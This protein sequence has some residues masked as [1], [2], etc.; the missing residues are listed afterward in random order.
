MVTGSAT[1]GKFIKV[2]H[3]SRGSYVFLSVKSENFYLGRVQNVWFNVAVYFRDKQKCRN[4]IDSGCFNIGS[5]ITITGT[6]YTI[7]ST[8]YGGVGVFVDSDTG[9]KINDYFY[10]GTY[11]QGDFVLNKDAT[12]Y[13]NPKGMEICFS[14]NFD[15]VAFG[16]KQN[17]H[18]KFC[19]AVSNQDPEYEN[20]KN[21]PLKQGSTCS[22]YGTLY[23][24]KEK[25]KIRKGG[26]IV[27]N[28]RVELGTYVIKDFIGNKT[29]QANSHAKK[30][31]IA[32]QSLEMI[33]ALYKEIKELKEHA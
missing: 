21:N 24:I 30:N 16:K 20:I 2:T 1:I 25:D 12:I 9:L 11:M 14:S 6:P 5:T 18:W 15:V 31:N 10:P 3:N 26:Y 22:L 32:L 29:I 23:P 19:I 8:Y 28:K 17:V 33:D 27:K 7:N 4:L 13:E